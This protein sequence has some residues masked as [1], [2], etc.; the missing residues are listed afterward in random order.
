MSLVTLAI[1][2][3]L[4][5]MLSAFYSGRARSIAA[6]EA[7]VRIL[8]SLPSHYGYYVALWTGV[9]AMLILFLWKVFEPGLLYNMIMSDVPPDIQALP[10]ERFQLFWRDVQALATGGTPSQA[11]DAL[12]AA[13]A[14]Y[15]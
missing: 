6:A 13:A 3:V 15:S 12:T 4:L 10:P 2:A 9:P 1:T 14:R 7:D 11:N 8:H 5:L